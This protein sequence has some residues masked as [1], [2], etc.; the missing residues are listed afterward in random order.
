MAN[1]M[2]PM[3]PP[4]AAPGQPPQLDIRTNPNQRQRFRNFMRQ[5]TRPASNMAM[6]SMY[7]ERS[8]PFP[9]APMPPMPM[10][11][12]APIMPMQMAQPMRPP[13]AQPMG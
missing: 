7:P 8:Q 11:A 10:P 9:A 1:F 2:G 6:P 3:A 4:Q 5:N 13:M 12:P